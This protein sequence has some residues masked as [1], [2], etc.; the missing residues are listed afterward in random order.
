MAD[1]NNNIQGVPWDLSN[2][3]ESADCPAIDA[4]LGLASELMDQMIEQNSVVVP[5]LEQ[6]EGLGVEEAAGGIAAA[7]EIHRLREE[8][9]LLLDNP[10]SYADCCMSVD[11]QDEAAQVLSGR[12][13][14][15]QKRFTELSQPWLQFLDLCLLYTSPSPRDLSTSRMPSSA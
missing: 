11:S 13:Q 3:Y 6:A 9:R 7:R 8:V 15:Y 5:L 2:E 12:L 10:E 1:V 14:S 4:D